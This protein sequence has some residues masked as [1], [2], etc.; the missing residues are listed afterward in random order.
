M[1]LKVGD[2]LIH[3]HCGT[4]W[5]TVKKDWA[6]GERITSGH[7]YNLNGGI[8]AS[9]TL[10]VCTTCKAPTGLGL[11]RALFWINRGGL[12]HVWDLDAHA[13][14]GLQS[15]KKHKVTV[16]LPDNMA[17]IELCKSRGNGC[18]CQ[19]FKAPTSWNDFAE[20]LK[21]QPKVGLGSRE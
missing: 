10:I 1:N 6:L 21:H 18:D 12:L 13:M 3:P 17:I 20:Q 15:H 16:N 5:A 2:V 19:S 8:G 11:Q 14:T 4:Y 9:G 7:F